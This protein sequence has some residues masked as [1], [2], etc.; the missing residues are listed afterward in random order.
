MD[1]LSA[2]RYVDIYNVFKSLTDI[3]E[4]DT[5]HFRVEL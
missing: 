3:E 2:L 5:R 1:A 4:D